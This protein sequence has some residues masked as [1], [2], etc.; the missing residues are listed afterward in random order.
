MA[1]PVI[2]SREG[3][4]EIFGDNVIVRGW[5]TQIDAR[6][7]KIGPSVYDGHVAIRLADDTL[8]LLYAAWE[9]KARRDP[10]E[11]AHFEGHEVMVIGCLYPKAPSSPSNEANLLLPCLSPV[12]NIALSTDE[13]GSPDQI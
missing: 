6:M 12:D 2:T 13:I 3:V 4:E 11:I 9:P 8:V 10:A 7:A 5:Y 1:L